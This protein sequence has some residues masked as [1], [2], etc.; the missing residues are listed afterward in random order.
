VIPLPFFS[1]P[2][3]KSLFLSSFFSF[4]AGTTEFPF[5]HPGQKKNIR[6]PGS[7]FFWVGP[8]LD[9]EHAEKAFLFF[10]QMIINFSF[11]DDFLL[12]KE[13]G[14][15]LVSVAPPLFPSLKYPFFFQLRKEC[16]HNLLFPPPPPTSE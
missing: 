16:L 11:D 10:P 6:F 8:A 1:R 5:F 4:L 15:P 13:V 14:L 12:L 9:V 2:A 7:L 3:I